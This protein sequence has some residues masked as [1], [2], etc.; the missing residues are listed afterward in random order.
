MTAYMESS[1]G[2]ETIDEDA[3][4]SREERTRRQGKSGSPRTGDRVLALRVVHA[5][6]ACRGGVDRALPHLRFSGK[7]SGTWAF[8]HRSRFRTS[9]ILACVVGPDY[10][11]S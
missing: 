9:A 6:A 2:G 1:A 7:T 10:L 3:K 8:A 4:Y 5:E 11:P